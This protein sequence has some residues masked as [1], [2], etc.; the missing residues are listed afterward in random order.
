M[1]TIGITGR[2]CAGKDTVAD[3]LVQEGFERWSLSDVL[4]EELRRR[5]ETITREALIALGLELRDREGP[6]VLARRVKDLIET[7]RVC[8]VSVRSP[9]EVEE[10]RTVAGFR[11][12]A[13]EARGR[14]RF[15]RER[16]RNREGAPATLDAF[17]ALEARENTD[18][19]KAQQLDATIALADERV[20]NDGTLG[21]LAETVSTLVA[22]WSVA[23]GEGEDGDG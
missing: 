4:R 14:T 20:T 11:L 17:K 7:D 16:E 23:P 12:L 2:N 9:A 3:F 13:V 6:A 5:G 18:D 19:P 10:L 15:D 1:L 21:D 22:R 8:L